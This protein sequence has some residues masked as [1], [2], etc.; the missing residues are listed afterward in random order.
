[1]M[2]RDVL[3]VVEAGLFPLALSQDVRGCSNGPCAFVATTPAAG[4]RDHRPRGA[5]EGVVVLALRRLV[6]VG[7]VAT[8]Q[9]ERAAAMA[10][11]APAMVVVLA[12]AC[13]PL[14]VVCVCVCVCACV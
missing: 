10:A 13:S 6:V 4:E 14:C 2:D 8:R 11:A 12:V 9:E 5:L 1:M 3:D 7:V